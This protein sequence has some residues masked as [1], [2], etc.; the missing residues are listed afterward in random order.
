MV[1]F[2]DSSSRSAE[3]IKANLQPLNV[4]A[5]FKILRQDFMPALLKIEN[6]GFQAD[7]VFLDPP[8]AMEELYNRALD[9]LSNSPVLKTDSLVIAEHQKRFD[10]GEAFANL[11]RIRKLVQ[12]DAAL[13][14]YRR[15]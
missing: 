9:C 6:M 7:F 3:L 14:F 4:E 12:A 11:R 8:Y 15:S 2:V 5:N 1:Y 10:P 13:S